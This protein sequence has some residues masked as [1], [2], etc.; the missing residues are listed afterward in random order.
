MTNGHCLLPSLTTEETLRRL[1]YFPKGITLFIPNVFEI[2]NL[3]DVTVQGHP[4]N[5]S[6][7]LHEP[8]AFQQAHF[9]H[10]TKAVNAE[11]VNDPGCATPKLLDYLKLYFADKGDVPK[12]KPCSLAILIS[13]RKFGI[14]CD[15]VIAP[16]DKVYLFYV[17]FEYLY[18]Y[19][20]TLD[21]DPDT[22]TKFRH[23]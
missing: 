2:I 14:C 13:L 8:V 7:I 5:R 15:D 3:A 9:F 19:Q 12:I 1:V 18:S 20:I 6:S 16:H 21:Q 4:A 23:S 22:T 10:H 17:V 11:K